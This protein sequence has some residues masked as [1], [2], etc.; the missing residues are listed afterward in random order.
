MPDAIPHPHS[1]PDF[2]CPACNV[3]RLAAVHDRRPADPGELGLE[4]IECRT[5]G[6]TRLA[7]TFDPARLAE[8]T[9]GFYAMMGRAHQESTGEKARRLF[10]T[11][12]RLFDHL[13]PGLLLDIGSERGLFLEVMKSK[14]WQVEGIEPHGPYAERCRAELGLTIHQARMEDVAFADRFDLISMWHVLEH[15]EDPV[16]GLL[17][18]KQMLKVGGVLFCEV[19]NIDSLG[20]RMAGP[21]W[22]GFRDP[23]HRWLFRGLAVDRLAER[24]G[25]EVVAAHP[26]RS[27][28]DWYGLKRGLGGRLLGR[29]YWHGKIFRDPSR[30]PPPLA[31]RLL[32]ALAGF[33]PVPR[34]LARVGE[35]MGLGEV[36]HI[37]LRRPS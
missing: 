35:A 34:L 36:L 20:A 7:Q 6:M 10:A 9:A 33:Y 17:K 5:C 12:T 8:Y 22:L 21:Y 26:A 25:F 13:T 11:R 23:T 2:M 29:D 28:A 16:G 3:P 31:R 37:W 32:A 19:P 30:P 24:T 1:I 4:L 14:G 27:P 18:C 15:L